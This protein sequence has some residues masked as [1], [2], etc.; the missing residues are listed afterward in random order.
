M[1]T[2]IEYACEK[3]GAQIMKPASLMKPALASLDPLQQPK[4]ANVCDDC[5]HL[6]GPDRMK[7][8]Q[9][10]PQ[11]RSVVDGLC[12]PEERKQL[13]LDPAKFLPNLNSKLRAAKKAEVEIDITSVPVT[14][15]EKKSG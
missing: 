6:T 1:K 14:I 10:S 15:R 2:I 11:L 3:C 7:R 4:G 9:W 13:R 8:F 5:G 12:S